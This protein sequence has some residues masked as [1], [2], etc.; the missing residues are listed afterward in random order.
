MSREI[1][2]PRAVGFAGSADRLPKP[3][4]RQL[5]AVRDRGLVAAA[6]VNAAA[7]VSHTALN[8]TASLSAEEA[9][10]IEMSPL[11]EPRYKMIVDNF[12]GVA[13]YIVAEFGW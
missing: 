6:R 7:Y 11:G 1:V 12:A 9:R 13:C 3:V 2:R 4:A 10:L 8:L 5:D